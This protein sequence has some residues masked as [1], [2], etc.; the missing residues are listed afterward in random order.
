[1]N[2]HRILERS[3]ATRLSKKLLLFTLGLSAAGIVPGFVHPAKAAI[4]TWDGGLF[5]TGTDLATAAN[6]SGDTLPLTLD[7]IQWNGSAPGPLALTVTNSPALAT[8]GGYAV[9]ITAA[10][11]ES[12]RLDNI[13]TNTTAGAANTIRLLGLTIA[14]GAG[15]FT[16]GDGVGTAVPARRTTRMCG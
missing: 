5:G 15:A 14:N 12:L 3:I 10:Q 9:D 1:M 6:W 16:L 4:K 8:A 7:T 11:T 2:P 13:T